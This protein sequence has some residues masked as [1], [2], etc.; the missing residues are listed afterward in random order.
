MG[1]RGEGR[2]NHIG[3][4]EDSEERE[5]TVERGWEGEKCGERGENRAGN[6]YLL[7]GTR[8]TTDSVLRGGKSI[9]GNYGFF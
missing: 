8:D 7:P 6:V 5:R 3:E 9:S 2:G 4:W 1:Q